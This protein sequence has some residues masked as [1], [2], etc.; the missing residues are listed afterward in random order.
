MEKFQDQL[1]GCD[2]N[3]DF[4]TLYISLHGI[5]YGLQESFVRKEGIVKLGD[6]DAIAKA[7]NM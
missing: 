6:S 7:I 1:C 3:L 2:E 4:F 5:Y